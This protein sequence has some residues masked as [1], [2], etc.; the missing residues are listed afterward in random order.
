MTVSGLCHIELSRSDVKF[1]P[2]I[3][4]QYFKSYHKICQSTKE[5]CLHT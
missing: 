5:L 1:V 2:R 3:Y 4:L